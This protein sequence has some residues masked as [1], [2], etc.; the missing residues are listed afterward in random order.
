[1]SAGLA[2]QIQLAGER[3]RWA[4]T[5]GDQREVSRVTPPPQLSM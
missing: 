2:E 3:F 4:P 5:N 1:M